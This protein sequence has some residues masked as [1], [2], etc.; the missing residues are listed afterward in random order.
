MR[1]VRIGLLTTVFLGGGCNSCDRRL[2]EPLP[3]D[4]AERFAAV[5]CA[6]EV[7]CGCGFHDSVAECEAEAEAAFE[8]IAGVAGVKVDAECV[9]AFLIS[10]L[11]SECVDGGAGAPPCVAMVGEQ[12][13]G[14]PCVAWN[15]FTMLPGQTCKEGLVCGF[16][17]LCTEPDVAGSVAM[18]GDSC[19]PDFLLSCGLFYCEDDK[20][21]CAER[22]SVGESCLEPEQCE[23]GLYCKGLH[24]G[25]GACSLKEGLGTACSPGDVSPCEKGWCGADGEVCVERVPFVCVNQPIAK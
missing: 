7:E 3:E 25:A 1:F 4:L 11:F 23:L 10:Q 18:V 12:N 6:A 21:A 22:T 16:S 2:P 8:K 17:G 9:E 14:E 13:I 5:V 19:N 20:Q 15:L 24:T